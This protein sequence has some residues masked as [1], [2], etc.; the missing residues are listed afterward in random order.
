[1]IMT[2]LRPAILLLLPGPLLRLPGRL[3]YLLNLH[4]EMPEDILCQVEAA[5]ERAVRLGLCAELGDGIETLGL[6]LD[7]VGETPATPLIHA[8]HLAASIADELA[9][10]LDGDR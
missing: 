7:R 4:D 2:L 3:L 6:P 1:M 9:D 5:L 10:A 8:L